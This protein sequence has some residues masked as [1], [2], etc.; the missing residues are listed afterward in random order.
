MILDEYIRY[1]SKAIEYLDQ[2]VACPQ[3]P[4]QHAM[5][6]QSLARMLGDRFDATG[7]SNE[8]ERGISLGQGALRSSD[9]KES[10]SLCLHTLSKL[11]YFHFSR[12]SVISELDLAIHMGKQA[13]EAISQDNQQRVVYLTNLATLH[14]KK[15]HALSKAADI[16]SAIEYASQALEANDDSEN[17]AACCINLSNAFGSRFEMTECPND[18]TQA[19]RLAEEALCLTPEDDPHS[20]AD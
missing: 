5:T 13:L 12:S 8:F 19:I 11:H 2:A 4:S 3:S 15:F 14:T 16:E 18:L 7:D 10:Q 17:H 1:L 9:S 6:I 20:L